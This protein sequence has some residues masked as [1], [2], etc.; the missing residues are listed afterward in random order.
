[1]LDL[2]IVGLFVFGGMVVLGIL[3][4][5]G[6]YI[7]DCLDTEED[8]FDF[9]WEEDTAPNIRRHSNKAA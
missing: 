2:L 7:F 4:M 9:D 5:I 3:T 6:E 8:D 1:M